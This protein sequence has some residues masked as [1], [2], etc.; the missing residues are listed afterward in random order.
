MKKRV[1]TIVQVEGKNII[2]LKRR[3]KHYTRDFRHSE[4]TIQVT[5][6]NSIIYR[7]KKERLYS[8]YD[9][10]IIGKQYLC[11]LL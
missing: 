2:I 6:D 3:K 11:Q 1:F 9:E 10:K 4:E 7:S 5:F 8:P